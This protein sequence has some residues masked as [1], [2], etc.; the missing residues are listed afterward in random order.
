MRSSERVEHVHDRIATEAGRIGAR[1]PLEILQQLGAVPTHADGEALDALGATKRGTVSVDDPVAN[2]EQVVFIQSGLGGSCMRNSVADGERS[3]ALHFAGGEDPAMV[4]RAV[5]VQFGIAVAAE[6]H[7]LG[8][9]HSVTT[10][11]GFG[12]AAVLVEDRSA[13]AFELFDRNEAVLASEH[14][15]AGADGVETG[16]LILG[17]GWACGHERAH[18]GHAL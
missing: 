15:G 17:Q 5:D 18:R 14:L 13:S 3:R 6:P 10:E 4:G 7:A 8:G 12:P 11:R 9:L 2:T 16:H 1:I